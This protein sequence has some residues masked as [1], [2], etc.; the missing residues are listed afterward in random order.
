MGK[1]IEIENLTKSY[2]DVKAV[3]DL[4]LEVL[5]GEMF[6]LV[7]PDGAGKTTLVRI[8]CG[9]LKPDSGS[10][11]I[12]D[13]DGTKHRNKIKRRIGYL[14][15]K[16]SL[17]G[18]LTVDE[19]ID[20]FARIHNI[21][22]FKDEKDIL[23]KRMGIEKF[24]S[25]LA[26]RLSGG[27]KQKLSLACTLIHSP[28]ILFL[29]EPTTGVDPVSRREFWQILADLKREG[30]TILVT[31]PY[32][33]EAERC[34]RVAFMYNGSILSCDYPH[35]I[36]ENFTYTVMEVVCSQIREVY[37]YLILMEEIESIHIFGDRLHLI[38]DETKISTEKIKEELYKK[39]FNVY[40]TRL[41]SPSLENI[42]IM[43]MEM[44]GEEEKGKNQ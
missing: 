43:K 18:D 40:D 6:C 14:S 29:D 10:F 22:R 20:F 8:L 5:K 31:T 36:K 11:Y 37:N 7:G 25:R 35:I 21:K 24:G 1:I 26:E 44:Q 42:F 12:F 3:S 34:D 9:I 2:R 23:L 4:N 30:I 27:M 32:M 28:D 19:N 17:Y 38:F 33:D 16:F 13:M 39:D 41:I 15:Q